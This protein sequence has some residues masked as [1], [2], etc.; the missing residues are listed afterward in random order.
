[1][2]VCHIR[3]DPGLWF[4]I[5]ILLKFK[6]KSRFSEAIPHQYLI[7][8]PCVLITTQNEISV[9]VTHKCFFSEC[10]KQKIKIFRIS[11][12]QVP[13]DIHRGQEKNLEGLKIFLAHK[14]PPPHSLRLYKTPLG[15]S[16]S[17]KSEFA[18]LRTAKWWFYIIDQLFKILVLDDFG[19]IWK[20]LSDKVFFVA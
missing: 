17:N 18:R 15:K 20:F 12:K 5:S 9:K 1:M 19:T 6:K 3:N 4:I 11:F 2:T 16:Y 14:M 8:S 7:K 10:M 13:I